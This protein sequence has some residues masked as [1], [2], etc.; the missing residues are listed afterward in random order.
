MTAS[1]KTDRAWLDECGV[2]CRSGLSGGASGVVGAGG[3]DVPVVGSEVLH[4]TGRFGGVVG[5]DRPAARS[6]VDGGDGADAERLGTG[7]VL[8]PAP[9]RADRDGPDDPVGRS[10]VVLLQAHQERSARFQAAG[11][12]AVVAPGRAA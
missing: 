7:R 12:V 8:V 9:G 2:G 6:G 4:D 3:W 10:A 11:P 5:P 1:R